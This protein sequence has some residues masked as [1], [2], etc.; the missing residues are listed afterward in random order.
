M[1]LDNIIDVQIDRQTTIPSRA[2]FGTPLIFGIRA[3]NLMSSKVQ[4]YTDIDSVLADFASTDEEAKAAT[5]LFSQDLRPTQIKIGFAD[6]ANAIAD[7]LSDIEEA[8][9]DWYCVISTS[10]TDADIEALATAIQTRNKIYIAASDS[11]DIFDGAITTDI[12]TTLKDAGF[13]R[14]ALIALKGG[15]GDYPDGA[16]AGGLLPTDPGSVTWKFKQLVGVTVDDLTPTEKNA[17]LRNEAGTGKNANTY[18]RVGGV[19]ITE[20]GSMASGEFIDIIR[21]VDWIQARIQERI[22]FQLVNLPKIPYTNAGAQVIVNEIEAVL[23]QAIGNDVLRADP[24]PVVTV[25]DVQDI[26]PIDRG[27][28]KLTTVEFEGQLAGA[29]HKVVIR[30]TVTV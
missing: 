18:T 14:T 27:N 13:D 21:G 20:E 12:A 28:R 24:A 25:P 2:G 4:T 17:V 23:A 22:Y 6:S 16:W 1:S 26:D 19:N 10:R 30:G 8:D 29:I 15:V 3:S 11:A 7:E 5:A 9:P